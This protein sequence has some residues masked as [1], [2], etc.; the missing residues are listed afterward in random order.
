MTFVTR[1]KIFNLNRDLLTQPFNSRNSI[2]GTIQEREKT[3]IEVENRIH[4]ESQKQ[5]ILQQFVKVFLSLLDSKSEV[6]Q[7]SKC[8]PIF[9][10]SSLPSPYNDFDSCH[11]SISKA[12]SG[13]LSLLFSLKCYAYDKKCQ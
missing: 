9:K 7:S 6:L 8:L 11:M 3:E 12:T 13:G 2:S 5:L 1:M 4:N 10:L